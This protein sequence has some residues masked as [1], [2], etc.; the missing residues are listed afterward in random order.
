MNSCDT[1]IF[2]RLSG[3]LSFRNALPC[4]GL[5]VI[6]GCL[7]LLVAP[8]EAPTALKRTDGGQPGL[9]TVVIDPGHGG[10]DEGTEWHGLA[11]KTLTLDVGQRV[12]R[13]LKTA[14]FSTVLTRSDDTFVT[15][16]DRVR[17][18]N[19]Y[20]DAVFVSIHFN[21][22]HDTSSS[23]V[24]THYPKHKDVAD[25]AWTWVGLFAKPEPPSPDES[26]ALAGDIQAA[27]VTRTEAKSRGIFANDFY[28]VHHTRCPAVLIEGG[29]VSNTFEAQ[30]LRNEVY[31]ENLAIG[32]SQ[33]VMSFVKARSAHPA[34]LP[35][36]PRD[37]P[38]ESATEPLH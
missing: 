38:S 16:P 27:I 10:K 20:E 23:G 4:V 11:E 37:L 24:Q 17:V 15:L 33:G 22:D 8:D 21:S 31:R 14:G 12:D 18:A 13:M 19:Q 2:A 29:F 9:P 7:T 26:E 28:V 1:G 32:I 3:W 5:V 36:P 30:L 25:P 35:L 34:P 6:A